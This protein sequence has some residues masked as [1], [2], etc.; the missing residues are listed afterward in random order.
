MHQEVCSYT[1]ELETQLAVTLALVHF[2]VE[3]NPATRIRMPSRL[4]DG[5]PEI[6]VSDAREVTSM[7]PAVS[8]SPSSLADLNNGKLLITLGE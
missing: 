3:G 2:T 1:R 4:H 5:G 6:Q 7:S 8:T